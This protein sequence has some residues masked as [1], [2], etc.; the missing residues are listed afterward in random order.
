MQ[1]RQLATV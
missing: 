1:C